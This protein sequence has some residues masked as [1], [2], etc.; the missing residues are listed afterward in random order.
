MKNFMILVRVLMIWGILSV[1]SCD[2]K[3]SEPDLTTPAVEIT[4]PCQGAIV[5]GIVTITASVTSRLA[6]QNVV[7]LVDNDTLAVITE[8]PYIATWNTETGQNYF[9]ELQCRAKFESGDD[10]ASEIIFV[11][12]KNLLFKAHFNYDWMMPYEG[13]GI[14]FISDPAG[15]LLAESECAGNANIE[16]EQSPQMPVI[17]E[18]ISVTTIRNKDGNLSLITYLEVPKGSEWTFKRES[19]IQDNNYQVTFNFNNIPENDGYIISS[20]WNYHSFHT[21]S[22]HSPY[23]FNFAET[24]MDFFLQLN[25]LESGKKYLWIENVTPGNSEVDLSSLIPMTEQLIFLGDLP[26]WAIVNLCGFPENGS[27]YSGKYKIDWESFEE[28]TDVQATIH[29]PAADFSDYKTEI[30]VMVQA[31]IWLE[32]LTQTVYGDIPSS[33]SRIDAEFDIV[34]VAPDNF[35]IQTTGIYDEIFVKWQGWDAISSWQAYSPS[36]LTAFSLPKLPELIYQDFPDIDEAYLEWFDISLI[37]YPQLNSY[38]EILDA[39]FKS[40][41]LFFNTINEFRTRTKDTSI[42]I[43]DRQNA[44]FDPVVKALLIDN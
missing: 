28:G 34:N 19:D 11:E 38:E 30:K 8:A 1:I 12:V 20:Q 23:N 25:T 35:E 6:V 31:S 15:N 29:I 18:T 32:Y 17:P 5:S 4:S 40:P 10:I 16:F 44:Q 37:E 24:P 7:F 36:Y 27:H 33:F 22:L 41:E 2:D 26:D 43:Q 9:H 13:T 21:L 14:I 3:S 39:R 42:N